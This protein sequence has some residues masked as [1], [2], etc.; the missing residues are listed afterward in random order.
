MFRV[1]I[2][3]NRA[4]IHDDVATDC[5]SLVRLVRAGYD[6]YGT[7]SVFRSFGER[8]FV[9]DA[10][11][12]VLPANVSFF[13]DFEL[14][15]S[16]IPELPPLLRPVGYC[17][18]LRAN[19]DGTTW[20]EFMDINDSYRAYR[21][22]GLHAS[23]ATVYADLGRYSAFFELYARGD[24][25]GDG[26]EDL[27]LHTKED[28]SYSDF[29]HLFLLVRDAPDSP[30]RIAWEYGVTAAFYARCEEF[31]YRCETGREALSGP[32]ISRLLSA[33]AEIV[34]DQNLAVR[35]DPI[36]LHGDRVNEPIRTFPGPSKILPHC[37]D[38]FG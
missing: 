35:V 24:F 38:T 30:I 21:I 10:L 13:T 11:S 3:N 16:V 28:F 8:C 6:A 37:P 9:F 15:P 33:A 4:T 25:N 14:D 22:T 20:R 7:K 2:K 27:L 34:G 36:G 32:R 1:E 12:R 29:D 31:G 19:R 5:R 18:Y 17:G 23:G 26:T